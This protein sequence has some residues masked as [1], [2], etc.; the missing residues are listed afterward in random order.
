MQLQLARPLVCFDLEST[1]LDVLND[2]IVEIGFVKLH[3]DGTREQIQRR[4]DPGI[5]IP[6]S[7]TRI[8]GIRN[9]DVRGLFG[10][11]SLGRIGAD[12]IAFV[13]DADL[14]G[15]NVVG[16]DLP[17]WLAECERHGLA[18]SMEGRHVVD[19]RLVFL[20]KEPSWDRFI[21]GPR[22]LNNAVLHYCGRDQAAVFAQRDAAD[23]GGGSKDLDEANRHSAVK[24][25]DAT[26]DVLLAQL[27]R[28]GD[29]PRDVPALAGWCASIASEQQRSM[30]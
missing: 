21:Q 22:N 16:Y 9:D 23:E 2:R 30:A 24:D 20:G 1:G 15:F 29:L 12:L 13:G 5:D 28:Y 4:V 8:H 3:P 14:A 27:Q 25:A 7:A 18:F 19:A 26:L 6:E 11:P 10:E 17:M